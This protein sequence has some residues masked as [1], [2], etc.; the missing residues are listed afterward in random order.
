MSPT[1]ESGRDDWRAKS[2]SMLNRGGKKIDMQH[3]QKQS[4]VGAHMIQENA[5]DPTNLE[6][7]KADPNTF[8]Q[9]VNS[10]QGQLSKTQNSHIQLGHRKAAT[11]LRH[12]STQKTRHMGTNMNKS[13]D[14][15]RFKT[16]SGNQKSPYVPQS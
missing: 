5:K 10:V 1:Q 16:A 12:H 7:E 11:E 6:K 9:R 8:I 14:A 4:V 2:L 13:V 3:S 15:N